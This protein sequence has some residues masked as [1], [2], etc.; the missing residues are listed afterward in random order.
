MQFHHY[1]LLILFLFVQSVGYT[2]TKKETNRHCL[3]CQDDG[4]SILERPYKDFSFKSELPFIGSIV[5]LGI[6]SEL[7]NDPKALTLAQIEALD[8]NDVNSFDRYAISKS[9]TKSQDISDIFQLGVIALPIIFVTNHHTRKDIVPLIAM[10]AEVMLINYTLTDITKKLAGRTR[11]LAYNADFSLEEKESAS[12]RRSFF[13][14]HTS[15][16]AALSFMMA[17]VMTDYH[18]HANKGF[19]IGIW[20]FA[21]AVPAITGYLRVRAGKHFPTDT[22]TGY[23]AGGLVGILVP[24]FHK[25]RKDKKIKVSPS[26]GW[27]QAAVRVQ[28]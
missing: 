25:K 16:T 13:S 14:G 15:H 11:P 17:K 26:V 18:P 4:H 6:T 21:A 23:I 3:V 28:F 24:Q 12:V 5:G 8:P 7:I 27:N 19:K 1:F 9:S 2:Q 22:I 10:S 20:S